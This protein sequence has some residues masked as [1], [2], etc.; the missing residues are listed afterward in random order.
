M[1]DSLPFL[2]RLEA[3]AGD[4]FTC[5]EFWV[6]PDPESASRVL[7]DLGLGVSTINVD[8]GPNGDPAGLLSDP[9]EKA[10]WREQFLRTLEFGST[11]RCPTIN[12]LAGG[13]ADIPREEQQ[14]VMLENLEWALEAKPPEVT[15]LLEPLNR[16]ERPH[17]L[18]HTIGDAQV[19]R[20]ALGEPSSLKVLFD[21]YHLY[22]EEGDVSTLFLAN[23]LRVGHVQVADV[24]GRGAPGTG[25]IDFGA[26]WQALDGRYDGWLGL[27]YVSSSD[28]LGWLAEAPHLELRSA[29]A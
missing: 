29:T 26:F 21:A 17:Y 6:A 3:A 10:W 8:P 11:I 12:V 7:T 24:P 28:G 15:L 25:A 5:V 19:V 27:E 18:L 4:G 16:A 20:A 14:K 2:A 1:Y 23:E 13:R 22:Q 9:G